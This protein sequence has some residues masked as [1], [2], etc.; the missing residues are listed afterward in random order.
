MF[1]CLPIKVSLKKIVTR[2]AI[3]ILAL[4]GI[5]LIAMA[6]CWIYFHP[7]LSLH[8]EAIV[9]RE[10]DGQSLTLEVVQPKNP[11]GKGIIVVV[12]GSW[13]SDPEDFET[14]YAAPFLR[15]GFTVFAVS[16]ISQPK[17]TITE[18]AGDIQYAIR[19]I[20]FHAANWK[21]DPNALGIT[22]GSSGGH[23]SLF[24]ATMSDRGNSP[25]DH[26]IDHVPSDVQAVA[27]FFPVTDLLNLGDSTENPGDGGPPISYVKGFGPGATNPK[28]WQSIGHH[29]SPIYHIKNTLPPILIYH[30]SGDTLVPLDQS[31]RFKEAADKK[32][33]GPV[34]LHIRENAGHGYLKM[35]I[36]IHHFARF[37]E[38]NL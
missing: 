27:A 38:A 1:W 32:S 17:V 12:S 15:T 14:W 5:L 34:E 3:A 20:R 8:E 4:V 2:I 10:R 29:L 11:N 26:P 6:T 31:T 16:H 24:A 33:S 37:F 30:G 13:K 28:K 19:F 23:L 21:I 35:M 9:Y 7:P 22:G 18:I 25:S 36:D